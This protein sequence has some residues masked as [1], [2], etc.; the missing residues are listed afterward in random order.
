MAGVRGNE[1]VAQATCS[2][3]AARRRVRLT[4]TYGT[5]RARRARAERR[6][7]A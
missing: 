7:V 2:S 5:T 1:G 3:G 6:D 4:C